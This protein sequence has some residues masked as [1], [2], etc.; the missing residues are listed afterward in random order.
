MAEAEKVTI[1]IDADLRR[2]VKGAAA[3]DGQTLQQWV[4]HALRC[5]L[6]ATGHREEEGR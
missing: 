2:R 3:L 4:A 6:E 1:R 5:H